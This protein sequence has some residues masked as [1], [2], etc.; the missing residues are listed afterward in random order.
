M[1]GVREKWAG[2][3]AQAIRIERSLND[4]M[5]MKKTIVDLA[6]VGAHLGCQSICSSSS[7]HIEATID[8]RCSIPEVRTEDQTYC[9]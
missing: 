7:M 4:L 6:G 3:K 1:E 8:S 2:T 9:G 5:M